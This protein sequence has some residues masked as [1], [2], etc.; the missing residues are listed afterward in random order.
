MYIGKYKMQIVK[1]MI[2]IYIK[3]NMTYNE[4]NMIPAI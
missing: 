2:Y 3:K 1:I 4:Q